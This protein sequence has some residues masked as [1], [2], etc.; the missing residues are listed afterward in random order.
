MRKLGFTLVAALAFSVSA[1]ANN[2]NDTINVAGK[3]DG[4]INKAK[5]TKYLQLSS[6]QNEQVASIC[7]YF[8]EQMKVA[9]SSK[10]NSDQKVRNAVYGNLKLMKNTLTEKQYSDYLR[11]MALTLRNKVLIS[12]NNNTKRYK[13]V[14]SDKCSVFLKKE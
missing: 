13:R 6:Q 10:K 1:F 9:N 7:D 8:Q 5:L 2:A 4:T 11:L 12:R 3:W 14:T